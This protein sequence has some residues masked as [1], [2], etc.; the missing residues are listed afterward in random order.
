M[1]FLC[2]VLLFNVTNSYAH[3]GTLSSISEFHNEMSCKSHG[4]TSTAN[5]LLRRQS[6]RGDIM[7]LLHERAIDFAY[8]LDKNTNPKG[9]K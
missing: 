1:L 2:L 6:E 4:G 5:L 3:V 8:M 7:Y 9:Y